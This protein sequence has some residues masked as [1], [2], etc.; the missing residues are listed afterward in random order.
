MILHPIHGSV[1]IV[2]V[3]P[4]III[5]FRQNAQ[6]SI[7]VDSD[8]THKTVLYSFAN[9]LHSTPYEEWKRPSVYY[10]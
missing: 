1:I 4:V 2:I 10:T 5:G 8:E 9:R 7:V 6:N 3:M